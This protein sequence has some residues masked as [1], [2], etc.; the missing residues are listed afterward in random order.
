MQRQ[1]LLF[2][3][4]YKYFKC[5][6]LSSG[7]SCIYNEKHQT[8]VRTVG[9]KLLQRKNKVGICDSLEQLEIFTVMCYDMIKVLA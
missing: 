4:V 6:A 2:P 5:D 3:T 7:I 8:V 1:L 9:N